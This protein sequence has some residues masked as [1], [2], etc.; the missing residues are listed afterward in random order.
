MGRDPVPPP[1][2]WRCRVIRGEFGTYFSADRNHP[3]GASRA[4]IIPPFQMAHRRRKMLEVHPQ[5]ARR[6]PYRPRLRPCYRH[7]VTPSRHS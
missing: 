7:R 1:V 6:S 5:G 2:D 3:R 4:Y